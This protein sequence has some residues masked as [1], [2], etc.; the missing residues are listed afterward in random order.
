VTPAPG[1]GRDFEALSPDGQRAWFV[2]GKVGV[3][4]A[5]EVQDAT[6]TVTHR[7][8][9][10]LLGL[11]KQISVADAAGNEVASI[12]APSASSAERERPTGR[13]HSPQPGAVTNTSTHCGLWAC[14]STPKMITSKL[15]CT[16]STYRNDLVRLKM[17]P[18]SSANGIVS[19]GPQDW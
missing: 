16:T 17:Y 1:V 19:S 14:T 9:G 10:R 3:R 18:C 2:D 15:R 7:F 13:E 12:R 4:P 6:G 11:P 5:A 8:K